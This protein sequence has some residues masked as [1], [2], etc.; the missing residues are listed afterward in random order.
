QGGS[1]TKDL[2]QGNLGAAGG[3]PAQEEE[4]TPRRDVI[5]MPYLNSARTLAVLPGRQGA[6]GTAGD[7]PAAAGE[8]PGQQE[9]VGSWADSVESEEAEGEAERA[10]AARQAHE[11][12]FREFR[13]AKEKT[14]REEFEAMTRARY[15][16]EP[17]K[18]TDMKA[19][20]GAM[21]KSISSMADISSRADKV[22]VT[23]PKFSGRYVDYYLFKKDWTVFVTEHGKHLRDE[24]LVR[25]FKENSVRGD[26]LTLV[27]H[28]RTM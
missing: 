1:V 15:P 25:S 4:T 23:W 5:P 10:E 28:A 26:A 24:E 18:T 20:M 21:M 19:A 8:R 13:D 17:P 22:K 6:A 11:Q 7:A 27:V 16:T 3:L 14:I 2:R 12:S 9:K